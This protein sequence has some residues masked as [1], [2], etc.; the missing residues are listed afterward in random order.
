MAMGVVTDLLAME[1]GQDN[2]KPQLLYGLELQIERHA[3]GHDGWFEPEIDEAATLFEG[4]E[5]H[6][7]NLQVGNE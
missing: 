2:G 1:M 5:R 6:A 7:R 4:F 3:K